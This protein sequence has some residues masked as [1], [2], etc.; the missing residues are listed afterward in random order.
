[1]FLILLLLVVDTLSATNY[2]KVPVHLTSIDDL[3]KLPHQESEELHDHESAEKDHKEEHHE[4]VHVRSLLDRIII[5]D[6]DDLKNHFRNLGN[7]QPSHNR[8]T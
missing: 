1:M 5:Q 7:P 4:P 8:Y 3:P 2:K 6:I